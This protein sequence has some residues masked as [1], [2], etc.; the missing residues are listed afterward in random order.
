MKCFFLVTSAFAILHILHNIAR[1]AVEE[2]AKFVYSASV[3]ISVVEHF[4]QYLGVYAG[5]SKVKLFYT[6]FIH[7]PLKLFKRNRQKITFILVSIGAKVY[8][9]SLSHNI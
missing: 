5:F 2:P 8:K 6:V 4:V 9:S 7:L 3:D 1:L